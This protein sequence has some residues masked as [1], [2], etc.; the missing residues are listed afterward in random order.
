MRFDLGLLNVREQANEGQGRGGGE[1]ATHGCAR[2]MPSGAMHPQTLSCPPHAPPYPQAGAAVANVMDGKSFLELSDGPAWKRR[3]LEELRLAGPA[4]DLGVQVGIQTQH[5]CLF[6][7][8][9]EHLCVG[10]AFAAQSKLLSPAWRPSGTPAPVPHHN[11][12]HHTAPRRQQPR[13]R[14]GLP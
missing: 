14:M 2:W 12:A 1:G 4:A 7:C 9:Y 8:I 3:V 11:L 6:V 5:G 10:L 13:D